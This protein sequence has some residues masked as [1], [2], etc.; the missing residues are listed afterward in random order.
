MRSAA[1]LSREAAFDRWLNE[2]FGSG[3]VTESTDARDTSSG[4]D[5]EIEA[6]TRVA[7][8]VST[9]VT[10]PVSTSSTRSPGAARRL[11]GASLARI[12]AVLLLIIGLSVGLGLAANWSGHRKGSPTKS[13]TGASMPSAL[14]NE[15]ESSAG[16]SGNPYPKNPVLW[17]KTNAGLVDSILGPYHV[18]SQATLPSRTVEWVGQLTSRFYGDPEHK[19]NRY[20]TILDVWAPENSVPRPEPVGSQSSGF[21]PAPLSVLEQL[22]SV[23]RQLLKAPPAAPALPRL[24]EESLAASWTILYG[25]AHPS[26]PVLW[27]KTTAGTIGAVTDHAL[28]IPAAPARLVVWVVEFRAVFGSKHS[29]VPHET[30]WSVTTGAAGP[31]WQ[32]N[33]RHGLPSKARRIGDLP[34]LGRVQE[35][36]LNGGVPASLAPQVMQMLKV[37]LPVEYRSWMSTLHVAWVGTTAALLRLDLP[38]TPISP[39]VPGPTPVWIV[40]VNDLKAPGGF[41]DQWFIEWSENPS[42]QPA[43]QN[44]I[45]AGGSGLLGI[46][47]LSQLGKVHQ[48]STSALSP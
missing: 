24:V 34:L 17:V 38:W 43:S 27:V 12:A 37:V 22:G 48:L 35:L 18:A 26:V 47:H 8:L 15:I 19:T 42:S 36:W 25:D 46:T 10:S 28:G 1:Q 16:I 7:E 21:A 39:T 23:H 5:D 32:F 31:A 29:Q 13:V 40:R 30:D 45:N 9:H 11:G 33:T 41:S 2:R 14:Y 20:S 6:M 3:T 4:W 44:S